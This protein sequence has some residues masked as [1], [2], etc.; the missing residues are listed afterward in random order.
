VVLTFKEMGMKQIILEQLILENRVDDAERT[1]KKLMKKSNLS[2]DKQLNYYEN[3]KTLIAFSKEHN[4]KYL[5]WMVKQMIQGGREH[6][7]SV[8]GLI[9]VVNDF[10]KLLNVIQQKDINSFFNISELSTVVN[11]AKDRIK[12]KE[13]EKKIKTEIDRVYEDNRWLVIVPKSHRASCK[14]S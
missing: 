4:H 7:T 3:F 6:H 11:S 5:Q 14:R 1:F 13:N 2:G 10:H 9:Y 12:Q 8:M